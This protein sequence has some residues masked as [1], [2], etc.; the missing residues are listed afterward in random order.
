MR[1]VIEALELLRAEPDI[2]RHSPLARPLD[3]LKECAPLLKVR[4][5]LRS[6][7]GTMKISPPPLDPKRVWQRFEVNR[8]DLNKLN[9]LEIRTLCAADEF[10]TK[11]ILVQAL[12]SQPERL[13]N[14]RCLYAMVNSYFA[15]WRDMQE[16]E[17][18]EEL[19][20][21]AINR[22]PRKS[23]AVER[24]RS[25]KSLFSVN[26]VEALAEFVASR[27]SNINSVLKLQYVG[28]ATRLA[29]LTRAKTA[30]AAAARFRQMEIASDEPTNLAYLQ[31]MIQDVLT[32]PLLPGA[33]HHAL[34]L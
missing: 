6:Y 18:L 19:L 10:A 23:P 30:E 5:D 33:L 24:W 12:Q 34:V 2:M 28:A 16:P 8:A 3:G 31:W 27:Q 1:N 20:K 7:V 29:V 25:A 11:P 13:K 17:K 9:S 14:A 15:R 4:D 26:A 22:Y 32:E 21:D